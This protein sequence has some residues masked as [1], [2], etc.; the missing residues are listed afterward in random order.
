MSPEARR[1]ADST[2]LAA[3]LVL[4]F[5][6]IYVALAYFA[7]DRFPY[8][9]DEY[10]T[11]LQAELFAKGLLKTPAPAHAEWLRIDHVV[12]DQYVRSK[13]ALGGPLLLS[14]GA[15]YG[16]AWLVTPI[17]GTLALAVVW[18]TVRRLLGPRPALVALVLLGAAPLYMFDAASFYSHTPTLL[19]LAIA[20]AAVAQW[21][22]SGGTP[23]LVVAGVMIGCAYLIRPLDAL[24][25]GAAM[26]VFRSPRAL[27][28]TAACALPF[29]VVNFWYQNAQFGSPF[30][31]GYHAYEPT[32]TAIYGAGA[33]AHPI[34]LRHLV[35][36]EQ[37]WNHI[38]IFGQFCLQW[39]IPGTVIAALFGA[40]RIDRD[41]PAR[42]MRNFS[43]ALLAVFAIALLPAISL[44]DD[45]PH[46]RYLSVPLIP[47]VLLAAAGYAPLCSA[48][49]ARFGPRVRTIIFTAAMLFGLAQLGSYIQDRVPKMWKREGLYEITRGLPSNALVI[50]RAQY[51]TRYARNGAFFDGLL[52]LSPPPAVTPVDIAAAY[53]DRP[54]WEAHEGVPWTLV[55]VR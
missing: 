51:P 23:Y 54:I 53:P 5:G 8:S 15:R 40:Q 7:L 36:A 38:D 28:V 10:S 45:G 47:L 55:R 12:I 29:V 17:E 3:G 39:T 24:L 42:Q 25:F 9:G 13:Y 31:D 37:W 11:A 32:F 41:S 22:R 46:P 14:L 34:S 30:T 2:A 43:L 19:V 49:V 44:P 16:A 20:F 26:I 52:Y 4:A 27:I 50:V 48:I 1:I 35:S 33:A 21:T 6:A 18:H